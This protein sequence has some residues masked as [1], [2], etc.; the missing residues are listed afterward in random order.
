M[1][2]SGKFNQLG[3][4]FSLKA[5]LIRLLIFIIAFFGSCC[6]T[7]PVMRSTPVAF[8][9]FLLFFISFL[10]PV[11]VT[12]LIFHF[13]LQFLR[14]SFLFLSNPHVVGTYVPGVQQMVALFVHCFWPTFHLLS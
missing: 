9:G 5:A 6:R 7:Y 11:V 8:F 4:Y 14:L 1:I 3:K 10:S 2:T 12:S 13:L